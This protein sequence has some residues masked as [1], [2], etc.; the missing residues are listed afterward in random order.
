MLT[1][2]ADSDKYHLSGCSI[3]VDSHSLFSIPNFD[4]DKNVV[5]F[6][7]QNN[8]STHTNKRK[9]DILVLSE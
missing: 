9:K 4:L 1:K 5:I 6:V 7:A 3:R 2:N 8:L